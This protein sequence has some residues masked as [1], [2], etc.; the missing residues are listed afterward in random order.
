MSPGTAS[1]YAEGRV[2]APKKPRLGLHVHI[3]SPDTSHGELADGSIG[4]VWPVSPAHYD[5]CGWLM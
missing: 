3:A 5:S 2:M 4:M 1:S